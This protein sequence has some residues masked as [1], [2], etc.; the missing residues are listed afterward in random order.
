MSFSIKRAG[1][2]AATALLAGLLPLTGCQPDNVATGEGVAQLAEN[3]QMFVAD[4]VRQVLAA[5]LF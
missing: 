5:Y 1:P 4:F 2:I 3:L